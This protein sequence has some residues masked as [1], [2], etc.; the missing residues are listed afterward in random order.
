MLQLKSLS[1]TVKDPSCHNEDGRAFVQQPRPSAAKE[2]SAQSF[3]DVQLFLTPW[4]VVH[5]TPQSVGLSRQ[6]YWSGLPCP[7]LG[8][9]PD[10]DT[11]GEFFTAKP[12]RKPRQMNKIN[13]FQ[14]A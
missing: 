11:A 4:T 5:H 1:A 8:D 2:T 12:L 3:S 14:N 9:L 6:E 13:I 7:S 10:S